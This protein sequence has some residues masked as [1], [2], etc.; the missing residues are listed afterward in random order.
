MILA[1][2]DRLDRHF[3]AVSCFLEYART[4]VRARVYAHIGTYTPSNYRV[5]AIKQCH[6]LRLRDF[7][8]IA[9]INCTCTGT[10]RNL[11]AAR[12]NNCINYHLLS[13]WESP[14]PCARSHT[15][16]VGS[17]VEARARNASYDKQLDSYRARAI[18]EY[19]RRNMWDSIADFVRYPGEHIL[20]ISKATFIKLTSQDF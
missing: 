5:D 4:L 14:L 15:A 13:H 19:T 18:R 12:A 16:N 20:K 8:E 1:S 17:G 3:I 2:L 7:G 11:G 9:E 6:F 10:Q